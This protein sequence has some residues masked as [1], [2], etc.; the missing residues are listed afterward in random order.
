MF[1]FGYHTL[2]EPGLFP[3]WTPHP[4]SWPPGPWLLSSLL[5]L[6]RVSTF[7]YTLNMAHLDL[8][9]VVRPCA[10]KELDTTFKALCL[11][12]AACGI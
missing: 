7:L 11:Q 8:L 10:H 4:S 6:V 12:T 2:A 9:T 1:V 5:C 3:L